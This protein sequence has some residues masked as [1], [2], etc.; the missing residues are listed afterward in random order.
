MGYHKRE[1][2]RGKYK[3]FSKIEE[4]FVELQDAHEQGVK[5]MELCELADLYGAIKGYVEAKFGMTMDD[6]ASM[7]E[8]TAAAFR[9]GARVE[10]DSIAVEA[11]SP[12]KVPRYP[13]GPPGGEF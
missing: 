1:I 4:E 10:K 5:I 2:P 3:E 8:R 11:D 7:N 9:S 13:K 6:I 12:R